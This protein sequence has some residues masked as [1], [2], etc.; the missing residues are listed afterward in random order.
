GH[1]DACVGGSFRHLA[2]PLHS[3]PFLADAGSPASSASRATVRAL[4]V[5]KRGATTLAI[6]RSLSGAWTMGQSVCRALRADSTAT[7]NIQGVR[8][9]GGHRGNQRATRERRRSCSED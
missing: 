3:W 5:G 4:S 7:P 1:V 8:G 6:Q 9:K 2:A